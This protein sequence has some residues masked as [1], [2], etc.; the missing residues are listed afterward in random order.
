M[1]RN[2]SERRWRSTKRVKRVILQVTIHG[3][4][5]LQQLRSR[6]RRYRALYGLGGMRCNNGGRRKES[7]ADAK[8]WVLNQDGHYDSNQE[9]FD[10]EEH[11][12]LNRPQRKVEHRPCTLQEVHSDSAM[13]EINRI[14]IHPN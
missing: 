8:N 9:R 6:D 4:F 7:I 10:E 5:M 12:F 13:P 3:P 11:E 14:R 1:R 2:I